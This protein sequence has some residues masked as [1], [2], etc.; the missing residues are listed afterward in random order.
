MEPIEEGYFYHIYN[1]G[2]GRLNLYWSPDDYREF[3]RKYRYYLFPAI[4]TYAWCLMNNHFHA[5]IRVRT[6]DEQGELFKLLKKEFDSGYFH[7]SMDPQVMPFVASKQLSHLMNSYTRYINKKRERT[8]TLVEGPL[9]R[10][11]II[12]EANF[13]HLVC[14]IH[15]NP[16]HH[17]VCANYTDY[18]YSSYN[19]YLQNRNL[20]IEREWVLDQFGGMKNFYEAHEEFKL[21]LDSDEDLYLE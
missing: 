4:Q 5:L 9:K 8:G 10:K 18:K 13:L 7:G 16:I 11:K 3:I 6:V 12:D 15:R 21:R 14:Y 2:A 20:V 1:R 17:K 19:D